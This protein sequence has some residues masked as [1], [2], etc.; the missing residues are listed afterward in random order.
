LTPQAA[1]RIAREAATQPFEKGAQALN[2]DWGTTLDGKQIQRWAQRMGERVSAQREQDLFR[3]ECG[4]R[5]AGPENAAKLLVIGMDGGRVQMREKDPESKSRWKEDKVA[6]ITSYVPGDGADQDPQPLVSTYEATMASSE[7]FGRFV[8]LEA[9]RRGLSRAQ[10]AIVLGDCGAWIDAIN[11]REFQTLPRV[12]DWYHAEARL[13]DSGRA[14]FG[15]ASEA[16]QAFR[17]EMTD[18][19]WEGHVKTVIVRLQEQSHR[20]GP[21]QAEDSPEHPRR[22]IADNIGY[23]E[24]NQDHMNYPEYRRR[25]WPIGS[26]AIEAGVKQFNKRVKGTEQ[27]WQPDGVES[28]LALRALW[29]SQDGRWNAY[30]T[31]RA[32]YAQKAA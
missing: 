30:W 19:L 18:L 12:A 3:L 5:P 4:Q 20:L 6:T 13:H 26:G 7:G 11:K 14:A 17:S 25:G 9:Q 31:H 27:F 32:A 23:F 24:R 2:E 21:P 29:L 10:E 28:A 15:S 8:A 16:G 1:R 22:I